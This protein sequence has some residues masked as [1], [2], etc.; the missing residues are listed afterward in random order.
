[1]VT[2][3]KADDQPMQD[4]MVQASYDGLARRKLSP[5][6]GSRTHNTA[7]V[8]AACRRTHS[9][10]TQHDCGKGRDQP[11]DILHAGT[12][13]YYEVTIYKII[14]LIVTLI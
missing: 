2:L 11:F 14:T 7:A 10:H 4:T 5:L 9:G 3:G 8:A 12:R 13:S 6:D 1:M